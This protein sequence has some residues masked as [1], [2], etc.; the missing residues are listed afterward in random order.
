MVFLLI[1]EGRKEG[2]GRG[3]GRKG[4]IRRKG[5]GDLGLGIWG[6]CYVG[7]YEYE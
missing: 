1:L 4:E 6:W 2:S 5:L 3:R 7:Y